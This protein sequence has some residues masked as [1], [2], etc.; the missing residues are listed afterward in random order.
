MPN[1]FSNIWTSPHCSLYCFYNHRNRCGVRSRFPNLTCNALL[2]ISWPCKL[3][4]FYQSHKALRGLE[5]EMIFFTDQRSAVHLPFA[6]VGTQR[7][8]VH[9]PV[10]LVRKTWPYFAISSNKAC[11]K[12]CI[13]KI[14]LHTRPTHPRSRDRTLSNRHN[15]I[16]AEAVHRMFVFFSCVQGAPVRASHT[17]VRIAPLN[18][19]SLTEKSSTKGKIYQTSKNNAPVHRN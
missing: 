8:A 2:A 7:S 17:S 16:F 6:P 19:A 9:R 12:T 1:A 13:S 5:K 4:A 18:L 11:I 14:S 15:A 10:A 3:F